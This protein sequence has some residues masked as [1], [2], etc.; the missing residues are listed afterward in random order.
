M[1]EK[2]AASTSPGE[3]AAVSL[4]IAIA[5]R[6][7]SVWHSA[8]AH[9]VRGMPNVDVLL[10]DLRDEGKAGP[11]I[12]R[13]DWSLLLIEDSS[14]EESRKDLA[15]LLAVAPGVIVVSHAAPEIDIYWHHRVP[16]T[17]QGDLAQVLSHPGRLVAQG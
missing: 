1:E 15:H 12:A 5:F 7:L 4:K 10:V 2:S 17:S 13:A 16:V 3:G 8:L 6:R 9:Y 11:A 14:A